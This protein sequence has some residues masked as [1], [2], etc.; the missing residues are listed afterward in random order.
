MSW[1]RIS[2]GA[3]IPEPTHM[4]TAAAAK[5]VGLTPQKAKILLV[6]DRPANLLTL[7]SILEDLGQELVRASSGKEALRHLLNDDYAVILLDVNMPEMD[8]FETATLIRERERSRHTPILF[9]T[10]HKD[11]EH[12]FRG[13][14]AGAVDFM[15]KP[16]NAEVLRSKVAI[17]VDLNRKTELL[18]THAAALEARNAELERTVGEL[19]K[20]EAEVRRLNTELEQRVHDRTGELTR[21]NEELKQFAYAASHDLREPLRTIASYTQLLERRYGSALDGDAQEFMKYIT[22]SVQRMDTLLNDLLSYSHQLKSQ[23]SFS[24]VSAEAVLAGV[25]MNLDTSIKA[26]GAT[27]VHEPL[28]EV[29]SDFV[30]LGQVFQNLLSN[31]IKYRSEAPPQIRISAEETD[32]AFVFSVTDNGIGI[33]PRYHEQ[34]FGIFKRLH[35]REFPGT[36]IGL[37]LVKRIVERHGGRVGVESE[38]G[39]GATFHFTIPK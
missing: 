22:E 24:P 8:G 39:K 32:E 33:D 19:A 3:V 30:Q 38:P 1:G 16:I 18:R 17:F 35:G 26:S 27:I 31:S 2:V 21:A 12:Q 28:P 5:D 36:G 7:E 29:F 9:I 37:A 4:T 15:Y 13:Y 20:A 25:L 11:D 14:Y 23:Q 10:A 34:I 6:D